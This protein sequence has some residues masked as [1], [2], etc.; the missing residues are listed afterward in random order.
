MA[1]TIAAACD[2]SPPFATAQGATFD[3]I[4]QRVAATVE[5][6]DAQ[7]NH[8]MATAADNASADRLVQEVWQM[9]LGLEPALEPFSVTRIDLL[10]CHLRLAGR[11][12]EGVPL[13]DA[14]FTDTVG[15]RGSLGPLGSNADIAL[16]ESERFTLVEPRRELWRCARTG[17]AQWA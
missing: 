8:R 6:Y 16:V 3:G 17:A 1:G 11:R 2:L 15:I 14:T 9:G 12:I 7:G 10:S 5:A 13:F 4:E